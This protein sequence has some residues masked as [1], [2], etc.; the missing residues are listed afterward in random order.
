M[1]SHIEELLREAN[2][3]SEPVTS[4]NSARRNFTD[5]DKAREFFVDV[6]RRLLD[7]REWDASS[8]PSSYALFDDRGEQVDSKPVSVGDLIRITIHGSGK[9]DWVRV[10]SIVR[11]PDEMVITVGPTY[12]PT[13][14]PIEK[15]LVSHFFHGEARNNFC[16][17]LHGKV[18]SVYVIGLNERQNVGETAGVLETVRNSAT[19]NLG[20]YL[21]IQKGTWI[22]FCKNFLTSNPEA[23][24]AE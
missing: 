17:Q 6:C 15:D 14:S 13:A 11:E 23:G 20:Y 18:V 22:E 3:S 16:V 7:I 2:S 5:E 21:G 24:A 4:V 19:A 8:S 9:Y 10:L 12:D 1:S